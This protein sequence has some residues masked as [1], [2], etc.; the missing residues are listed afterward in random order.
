M[1]V[2]LLSQVEP[3]QTTLAFIFQPATTTLSPNVILCGERSRPQLVKRYRESSIL[4]TLS[5]Q[6]SRHPPASLKIPLSPSSL[7]AKSPP[8]TAKRHAVVLFTLQTVR[9]LPIITEIH[10]VTHFAE[11]VTSPLCIPQSHVVARFCERSAETLAFQKD[12]LS[13]MPRKV[14]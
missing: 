10:A 14:S 3:H 2:L 11:K 1:H 4:V 6:W 8:R 7:N 12:T 9:P 13:S 5:H